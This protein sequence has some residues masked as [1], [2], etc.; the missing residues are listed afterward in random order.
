MNITRRGR[1]V[2]SYGILNTFKS[3]TGA[4]GN[5][6]MGY[7]LDHSLREHPVLKKLK[8][9][10]LEHPENGMM[11]AC[12]QAQ[13][14]ANLAK[15]IKAKKA[16][17]VGVFT[18]YNALN[19]ALA[20]P[21]DGKVVA[22]DVS[23]EF[24][25][26]GKPFW[27]EAGVEHKI[28]LRIQP[29]L[30]T[31]DELVAAGEAETFDFAFIDA[32]KANYDQYYEKCLLLIRKGGI[33]AIDNVLWGG[34]VLNPE[35]G[36]KDTQCIHKLNEKIHRDTRVNIS[37]I[38][39]GDGLNQKNALQNTLLQLECHFTWDLVTEDTDI[40]YVEERL[41]NQ[42][43]VSLGKNKGTGH[44]YNQLAYVKHLQGLNEEAIQ[45]LEKDE[46]IT[47]KDHGDEF[48]K[49]V[50][51]TY[52]NFAW[53][54]YHMG[55]LTKAQSYLE[56]LEDICKRLS[57]TALPPEVYGEK[58]WS[59]LRFSTKHSKRAQECFRKAL[60]EE[61]ADKEWN[62]GLNQKNALQNTLLQLECHFTWDLV[63]EDTD[64][65]YVEER[66]KN[67][68][69]VSLGKNKGTGH[70]Y[71][72]LAYVKHLQGLNEEAIQNLEKD[73]EIT[74]KDHGDEFEKLVIVTYG[75]FAWVYYH[76][77]EL[78]KAQSYLEKL[79]D[80][81][82]RLSITAL[83]PEVYGEKG[84]SL[85][86]F[87]S[88]HSKRAQECFRK[89]LKEEPADKEWNAGYA[90][91]L[92]RLGGSE[93]D[94]SAA[95]EQLRRALELNPE[96]TMIMVFLGN[97]L[98]Q[99]KQEKEALEYIEK[100]LKMS[101][102]NPQVIHH[103]AKF[104]K[105]LGLLDKS[106]EI[107]KGALKLL[108]DEWLLHHQIA[109]CY[110][111]KIYDWIRETGYSHNY[112]IELRNLIQLCISHF[113][114]VVK[115]KPFYVYPQMDLAEMYAKS[116][117]IKKGE[118]IFQ[119][120]FGIPDM[121]PQEIQA[122]HRHY[123]NFLLNYNKSESDAIKHYKEGLKIQHPSKEREICFSTLKKTADKRIRKNPQD[124][125][126]FGILGFIHKMK[127]IEFCEKVL[128]FDCHNKE[129]QNVLSLLT[130]TLN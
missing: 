50:I 126:A 2:P 88:K 28:D 114:I 22:C 98:K 37:M 23:E 123:G 79:E 34:K 102:E 31:L 96:D 59:L 24:T 85:L 99:C 55:E 8:L 66:L 14:M 87:S 106:L 107:L 127:A 6:L 117:N 19:L 86:K 90:I 29:A 41:K 39:V 40:E 68:I 4:K 30:Q 13:L 108:P 33:I 9:R 122:L 16:I 48:E 105:E 113:E 57:I 75:N 62:A 77:G 43:Q 21:A 93:S 110:K 74:R 7:V 83:P 92:Y 91:A 125:E 46:E 47:R 15:L 42:K 25:S 109:L 116:R 60:K 11:V 82:K 97:K 100:A 89:A 80:I 36:D 119:T 49:L 111:W 52:G 78:T 35:K 5:P 1:Q 17:E 103:V 72:Q 94:D 67:Q 124:A 10:T 3:H 32:D 128:Q 81:C 76:M 65:E 56:K 26:V 101:P 61:P 70:S 120:L 130:K 51:V 71:N 104:F 27:K 54:Y 121:K 12:E 63:T 69:Q 45:N 20:L 112:S 64:I 115:H 118:E 95:L 18:G 38:T 73:E 84:W 129:Y 44:S 58:G 53:V